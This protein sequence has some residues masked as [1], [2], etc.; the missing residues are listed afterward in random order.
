MDSQDDI[1]V[2]SSIEP[3]ILNVAIPIRV[4]DNVLVRARTGDESAAD[5]LLSLASC[6]FSRWFVLMRSIMARERVIARAK[7]E[8]SIGKRVWGDLPYSK[9]PC[10]RQPLTAADLATC[11]AYESV[12]RSTFGNTAADFAKERFLRAIS[13]G[14]KRSFKIRFLFYKACD[15]LKSMSLYGRFRSRL[16]D[17]VNEAEAV[18]GCTPDPSPR[19]MSLAEQERKRRRDLAPKQLYLFDFME[20][21]APKEEKDK[22]RKDI[23]LHGNGTA[24]GLACGGGCSGVSVDGAHPVADSPARTHVDREKA[25]A[26]AE[27]PRKREE[28]GSKRTESAQTHADRP[29]VIRKT[30]V[31]VTCAELIADIQSGAVTPYQETDAI[32]SDIKKGLITPSEAVIFLA[33]LGKR[34]RHTLVST[35]VFNAVQSGSLKMRG[36][37]KQEDSPTED[38]LDDIEDVDDEQDSRLPS[39]RGE[40]SCGQDCDDYW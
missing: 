4:A 34:H 10:E 33:E 20:F 31:Y 16:E 32:I 40:F 17:V 37:I 24:V 5:R 1:F 12:I 38:D 27:S 25:E 36:P 11:E 18:A 30:R 22:H 6:V 15:G 21:D 19:R 13:T 3:T 7:Y 39:E 2:V 9:V 26:A 8:E 23:A 35:G 14:D 29:T 28:R